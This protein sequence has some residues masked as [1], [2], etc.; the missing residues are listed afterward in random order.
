MEDIIVK[1]T[2]A[3]EIKASLESIGIISA[4]INKPENDINEANIISNNITATIA[5]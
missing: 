4:Q 1:I 2:P 3:I 5:I